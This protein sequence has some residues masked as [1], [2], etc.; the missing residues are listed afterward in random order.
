LAACVTS[1]P[2]LVLPAA[3]VE[4]GL[5]LFA[6]AGALIVLAAVMNRGAGSMQSESAQP[7]DQK[8]GFR[9]ALL[10]AVGIAWLVIGLWQLSRGL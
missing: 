7:L 6:P 9:R 3:G 1:I 8:P 5:V 10:I 2:A 4:E